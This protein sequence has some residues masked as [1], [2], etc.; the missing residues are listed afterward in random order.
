MLE[1]IGEVARLVFKGFVVSVV[2]L[3]DGFTTFLLS[4]AVISIVGE[5]GGI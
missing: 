5:G 3:R 1:K 2:V 4:V